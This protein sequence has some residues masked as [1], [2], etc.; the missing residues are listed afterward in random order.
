MASKEVYTSDKE[1]EDLYN[2][3]EK[4]SLVRML[5]EKHRQ[6]ER[7]V[8]KLTIPVVVGRSEQLKAVQKLKDFAY[9]VCPLH[10]EDDL[11]EIVASL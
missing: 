10:R 7:Q 1:L 3:L 2:S 5:I 9:E 6:L 11:E 8:K 4:G